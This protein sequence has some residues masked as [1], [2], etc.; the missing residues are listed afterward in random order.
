MVFKRR[1]SCAT[2]TKGREDC[3]RSRFRLSISAR[4]REVL[5]Q[6]FRTASGG[7]ETVWAE[8]TGADSEG[9]IGALLRRALPKHHLSKDS[10]QRGTRLALRQTTAAG[11]GVWSPKGLIDVIHIPVTKMDVGERMKFLLFALSVISV[12]VFASA[13]K[14][15][16][17]PWCARIDLGDEVENCAFDSFEQCKAS[18]GGVHDQCIKN[19]TYE[20]PPP[21]NVSAESPAPAQAAVAPLPAKKPTPL[22][23]HEHPQSGGAGS[24][25]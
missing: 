13:A 16:N 23:S 11:N 12:T 2:K 9:G 22:K 17:Y 4:R 21:E 20:P 3:F 18:L 24:S 14:A 15:Q 10:V 1:H 6:T 19:N 25:H 7:V 8:T 5:A